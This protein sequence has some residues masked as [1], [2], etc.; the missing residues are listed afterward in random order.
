MAIVD[1]A[2]RSFFDVGFAA[3][4]IEA[5][6]Q[7]AGV[8]KVTI[9]NHFTDKRGLF[10]ASVENECEKIRGTLS[11]DTLGQGTLEDRLT[12]LGETM[13]AF[14]AREEMTR[15]EVR[16]A[17]ETEHEPAVG[18]AFLEAG[19]YRMTAAFSALLRGMDAAGELRIEDAELAAEQFVSMCKGLGDL[20][21]RFA[22]KIDR[23]RDAQR[24]AGAVDVFL[25]AYRP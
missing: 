1:A 25:A 4:S 8:S 5:V 23:Q 3:T 17:A 11:L 13:S 15:F 20:E 10:V 6:A 24:I 9:Y 18:Q 2:T 21:R 16:I 12:S 22:G 19:P 7:D 14:L